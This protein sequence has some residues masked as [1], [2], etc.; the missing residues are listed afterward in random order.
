MSLRRRMARGAAP[1]TVITHTTYAINGSCTLLKITTILGLSLQFIL[2]ISFNSQY[3]FCRDHSAYY[4]Y[5]RRAGVPTTNLYLQYNSI[6]LVTS[7]GTGEFMSLNQ[8]HQ[9]SNFH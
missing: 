2:I 3:A 9:F 6:D 8:C 4:T 1:S 5:V 7:Q